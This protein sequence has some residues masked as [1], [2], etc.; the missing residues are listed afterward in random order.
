MVARW[1]REQPEKPRFTL[2]RQ[3]LAEL[4]REELEAPHGRCDA[5]G[6][7]NMKPGNCARFQCYNHD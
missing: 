3:M 4:V 1:L 2:T 6:S 5:C 7:P